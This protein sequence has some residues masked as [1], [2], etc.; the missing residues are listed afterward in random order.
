M[1]HQGMEG[2]YPECC[3]CGCGNLGGSVVCKDCYDKCKTE[4]LKQ[5]QEKLCRR[6]TCDCFKMVELRAWVD[7]LIDV[8]SEEKT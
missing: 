4:I 7:A 8:Q 5:V 2:W 3:E 6:E 1:S